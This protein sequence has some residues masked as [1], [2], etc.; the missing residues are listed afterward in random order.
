M[1]RDILVDGGLRTMVGVSE[2]MRWGTERVI[3]MDVSDLFDPNQDDW[4]RMG[5]AGIQSR[6]VRR[7][8]RPA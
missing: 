5:L 1:S 7:A 3:A 6:L 2:A 8:S 4:R